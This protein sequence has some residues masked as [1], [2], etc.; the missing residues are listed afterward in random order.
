MDDGDVDDVI[1]TSQG[2]ERVVVAVT[3]GPE[4]ETL[5][6]RASRIAS[7]SGAELMVVHVLR[8]TRPV[9][10][11]PAG[12]ARELAADV[13]ASA[14]TVVG[15][16]IAAA[17]LDFTRAANATQLVIG[18]S[19]RPR[20]ARLFDDGIGAAVV[21]GSGKIDVHIVAHEEATPAETATPVSSRQRRMAAWLAA[22]VVPSLICVVA[23]TWLEQFLNLRGVSALFFVGV[24]SVALL[25]GGVLPA[26]FS[27]V[28]S[29]LLLNYY[30]LTPRHAFAVG[31]P[32]AAV[33]EVVLLLIAV[34]VAALVDNAAKREREAQRASEEA[35]L[36]TLFAG[37]V[38]RGADL[39]ALLDR[40]REIYGQQ[41]VT[42]LHT[43]PGRDRVV[44]AVGDGQLTTADSADTVVEVGGDEFLMLLAGRRLTARDR[45]ILSA[46][47]TQAA[48]LVEQRALA[49]E[50][51]RVEAFART[52]ELRRSLLSAVSHDLR[53]P[54]AVAKVSVSSLRADDVDFSPEDTAELLTSVEE[55]IDQLTAVVGNLLDSSRLAAGV[56]HPELRRVYLEEVVQ[57]ALVGIGQGT[58]GFGR[59]GIDRVAVD[60]GGNVVMAD[61]GLLE[62]VLA[63]LIDNALRYA[64]DGVVR[65][66]AGR[67]DDRVRISVIDNGCGIPHGSEYDPFAAFQRLG[68][69]DNT[70]GVGLGLSVARGFVEAM[71]G[72]IRT[73]DT[74][75]GGLTV[76]LDLAAPQE[77]RRR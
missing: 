68:D 19:R 61:A 51:S 22:L 50:A 39:D 45:K 56:V 29:S 67:V 4:S 40:V 15:D 75:G 12:K 26:V 25:G 73:D 13:H 32:D 58:T 10:D 53:T 3:G 5:V 60:V 49:G 33:T 18:T 46:V 36:L 35:E 54:L 74:P 77:E 37:S 55:S 31:E 16:D 11:A 9:S 64:P 41:A 17:L 14:H 69:H 48:G 23:V 76:I 21:R 8:G 70:T 44:A 66:H 57:R 28:L 43:H 30:M 2:R 38:L 24:L 47:A 62:R 59:S 72:N 63:N 6:R 52:D 1:G 34:A 20:W 65:I 42:M 71:G 27:A 7:K